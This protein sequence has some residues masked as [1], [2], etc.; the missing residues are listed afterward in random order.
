[1][2]HASDLVVM[3]AKQPSVSK[4]DLGV[5]SAEANLNNAGHAA[6]VVVLERAGAVLFFACF[7]LRCRFHTLLGRID[8]DLLSVYVHLVVPRVQ[9]GSRDNAWIQERYPA[10]C[11]LG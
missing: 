1:M 2:S 5:G 10:V 6:T 8:L 11:S 3:A 9:F 7:D 4:N